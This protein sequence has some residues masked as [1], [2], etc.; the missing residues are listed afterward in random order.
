MA[1]R[2]LPPLNA[3]RAFEAAARHLSFS[4]AASELHVTPA[5]VSHQIKALEADLGLKLFRRLNREVQLTD[6]GH[7][8]LPGLRDAFDRIAEAIGRAQR[9]D[10]SGLLT[11]SSSPAFAAKWLVPR[12]EKFRAR[13][14][15]IDLRVDA[16]MHLVDFAREGV[17]VGLRYGRGNYPGLHTELL[18]RTE[19]F[20]VCSPALLRGDRPLRKPDDLRHHTLIHDET[21][22]ADPSCPDWAMWLRATG[23]NGIDPSRGVRL[24]QAALAIDAAIGGRGVLLTRNIF[25]AQDLAS[26]RLVRPFGDGQPVDF[27]MYVA[28]PPQLMTMAKVKAFRDW[29]FEEARGMT[30][31]TKVQSPSPKRR[32]ARKR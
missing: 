8:C 31:I 4:A 27:A 2:R 29:L 20:P 12:L 15:E 22:T 19:V 3:L 13:H 18:L 10:A 25:A 14:P 6:A 24:N 16:S 30:P 23:I 21:Q 1:N 32:A 28:I 7:A 9:Q 5:A 11:V 17:H 26:G